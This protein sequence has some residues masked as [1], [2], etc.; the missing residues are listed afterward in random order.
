MK[1]I[2]IHG[3]IISD[4]NSYNAK[5]DKS[6]SIISKPYSGDPDSITN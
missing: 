6:T 4:I 5:R 3:I 1:F 2:I